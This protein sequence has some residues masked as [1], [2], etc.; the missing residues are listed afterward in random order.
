[1]SGGGT[2]DPQLLAHG[3]D[4][5]YLL[6]FDRTYHHAQHYLGWSTN[7]EQRLAQH[8]AG[9][10]SPLIAAAIAH[11]ITFQL[12]A[13]WPGDRTRERQLHRYKNSAR[14]LCPICRARPT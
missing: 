13:T 5:I 6:H 2:G 12:A 1:M 11:G 14:R 4:T 7:L 8:R 10:G 3:R 9:R